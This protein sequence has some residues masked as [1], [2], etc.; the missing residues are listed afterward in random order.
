[1][2]TIHIPDEIYE[3]LLSRAALLG[4]TVDKLTTSA[5][6]QFAHESVSSQSQK[7]WSKNFEEW[8]AIVQAR[9]DRYP[10]GFEADVSRESIYGG[11]GE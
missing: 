3:R 9:A 11:C 5:L 8:M 4:T 6:E 2:S 1:M 10:P 7:T